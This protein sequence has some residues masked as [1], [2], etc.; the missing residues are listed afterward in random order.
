MTPALDTA[1]RKTKRIPMKLTKTKATLALVLFAAS[2]SAC[3]SST[4]TPQQQR[5]NAPAVNV[6]VFGLAASGSDNLCKQEK[7]ARSPLPRPVGFVN[8]FAGIID[9]ESERRLTERLDALQKESE[10]EFAVATVETT[11]DV[12]IFDYSLAVAC[13]W[14]VGGNRGGVLLLVAVNDRKLWIQ[15]NRKLQKSLPDE[16][17]I[18]ISER[19]AEPFSAGRYG[20]GIERAAEEI[21][22]KLAE[23]RARDAANR[24]NIPMH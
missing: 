10:V 6:A 22:Q 15:V 18:K 4:S 5:A 16:D 24:R 2:A 7:Y 14:G 12:S 1:A 8:D 11:G 3:R 21:A 17:V 19:M 23:R 13:G 9:E 20:E